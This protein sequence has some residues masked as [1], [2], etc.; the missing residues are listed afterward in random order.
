MVD[1]ISLAQQYPRTSVIIFAIL[2]SF[3]ISLVNYFFLNKEKMREI[4]TRQKELQKEMKEHQKA[5]NSAKM[6]E[7]NK[8]MMSHT[9]EMMRHSMVPMLI[10]IVPIIFLF[11]FVRGIFAETIIAKSWFWYYLVAAIASSM[12]FR[13]IMNLP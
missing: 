13:K 1:F 2:I 8:E 7:L 4:K 5:G 9:M 12:L 6:M 11:S 10:T 3:L